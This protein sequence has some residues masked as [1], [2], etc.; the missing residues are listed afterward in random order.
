M[1]YWLFYDGRLTQPSKAGIEANSAD[2]AVMKHHYS[3]QILPVP[4]HLAISRFHCTLVDISL[5]T[6]QSN[7]IMGKNRC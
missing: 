1:A 6:I 4:W 5:R 2:F 3:E 7:T